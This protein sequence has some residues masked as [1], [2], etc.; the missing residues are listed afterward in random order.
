VPKPL[1][2]G[3]ETILAVDWITSTCIFRREVWDKGARWQTFQGNPEGTHKTPD[4]IRF[5]FSVGKLGYLVAWNDKNMVFNWGFKWSE[6]IENID[7]YVEDYRSNPA[8]G[9]DMLRKRLLDRGYELV[10]KDGKYKAVPIKDA[11]KEGSP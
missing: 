11:G 10:E 9:V 6:V 7:Y 4:D 8:H 2:N 1:T 5:S 3:N